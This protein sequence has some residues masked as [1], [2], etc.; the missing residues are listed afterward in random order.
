[1]KN[2]APMIAIEPTWPRA[3]MDEGAA[4]VSVDMRFPSQEWRVVRC[5]ADDDL[6]WIDAY[7]SF[8]CNVVGI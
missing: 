4:D 2:S 1:M 5:L 7:D 8:A 3:V 6:A